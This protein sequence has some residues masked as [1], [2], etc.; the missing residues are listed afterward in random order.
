MKHVPPPS[1][2]QQVVT[3]ER[4]FFVAA[5]CLPKGSSLSTIS[6][7][8]TPGSLLVFML[9]EVT[10]HD[11]PSAGIYCLELCCHFKVSRR[12]GFRLEPIDLFY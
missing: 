1:E 12:E 2:A 10:A 5:L 4:V 9:V 11:F 8:F 3:R 7:D 6:V